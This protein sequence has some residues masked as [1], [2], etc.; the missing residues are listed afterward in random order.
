[1][2]VFLLL[3]VFIPIILGALL[4]LNPVQNKVVDWA[5][6]FAS[7]QLETEISIGAIYIEPFTTLRID[8]V[9][10]RD[11]EAD[12]L[13]FGES[14]FLELAHIDFKPLNVDLA[15]LR[16]RKS[17]FNLQT[18]EG[19]SLSNLQ[20]LLNKL[21]KSEKD[22]SS[23]A[24]SLYSASLVLDSLRFVM[25]NNN[26]AYVNNGA[27]DFNHLEVKNLCGRFQ[28]IQIVDDSISAFVHGMSC[29][30]KSGLIIRHFTSAAQVSNGK[31][32]ANE[33]QLV[34]NKGV[35]KGML[36]MTG[37]NWSAYSDFL[38]SVQL[39]ASLVDSKIFFDDLGYF[40]PSIKGLLAPMQF[41][42]SID[43]TISH[44]SA[45]VDTLQFANSGSLRGSV[46]IN[47]LPNM[48]STFIDANLYELYATLDDI[49]QLN[50]PNGE[51]AYTNITL[52][53]SLQKLAFIDF[54]GRFTGFISDFNTYGTITTDMGVLETD[55]NIKTGDVL[56][57]KGQ[58]ATANF[59]LGTLLDAGESVG[60]IGFQLDVDGS[61][62]DLKSLD[63][64]AKGL[65]HHFEVL[66]YD[67]QKIQLNGK[68]ANQVFKGKVKLGD[69]NVALDFNGEID[70]ADKLPHIK[71][72]MVIDSLLLGKLNLV[73]TDTHGVI[74]GIAEL[75]LNGNSPRTLN[76][77]L[78][79]REV[80]YEN[81]IHGIKLDTL[82]IVDELLKE[83]HHISVTSDIL[84]AEV[85]GGTSI[86]DL[87]YAIT[88]VAHHYMPTLVPLVTLDD[89][90]TTQQFKFSLSIDND[91][92]LI[93]L[94]SEELKVKS[95]LRLSGEVNTVGNSFLLHVDTLNWSYGRMSMIRNSVE[96]YPAN[97]D[98]IVKL[99]ADEFSMSETYQLQQLR[100]GATIIKDSVM[101]IVDWNNYTSQAD[102]GHVAFTFYRDTLHPYN[103]V[104]NELEVKVADVT[105]TSNKTAVLRADT[106]YVQVKDLYLESERGLVTCSGTINEQKESHLYFKMKNFDLSYL[107]NFGLMEQSLAG[108][109]ESQLDLSFRSGAFI[110][111][112][113]VLADSLKIDD[114]EIG[115][116]AGI[117]NYQNELKRLDVDLDLTYQK[118]SEFDLK[119]AYYPFNDNDQL[120]LTASFH[121]FRVQSLEP[122]V[123]DMMNNMDG[124]VAG[125]I[126]ISGRASSPQ[127]SGALQ[128]SDVTTKVVYLNTQYHIPSGRV[129][130]QPQ[131]IAMQDVS[132]Y[133]E[134]ES[135]AVLNLDFAHQN[136]DNY[137]YSVLL[138]ADNFL[139][140]NTTISEN[141]DYYGVANIS[142]DV[143]ISGRAELT[144]IKVNASTD[145]NTRLAI[146]LSGGGEVSDLDYIRF[147]DKDGFEV[148]HEDKALREELKGLEMDFKLSVDN[149]A[150]VQIIFDEKV[151]D[152]IKVRGNGDMLLKIDNR[153]QFNM[154][155]DYVINSGDYLF[156]LQNVV[157]KRFIVESGSRLVWNGDPTKA[158]VDIT[159][160]YELK[161]SPSLMVK[162]M[163]GDDNSFYEQRLPVHVYL[164]MDG[165]MTEPEISFDVSLPTL[166]ETDIANQ[167]LNR[168]IATEEQINTQ[169][170]SLLLAGQFSPGNGNVALG[171][172]GQSTGFEMISN[173]LSNWASKYSDK[174]D[175]GIN[176]R[177][178]YVDET[179]VENAS[180]TELSLST[181][182]LNDRLKIE[183]NG[184]VQGASSAGEEAQNNNLA[185]EF[186]VEYNIN[187]DGSLK[188][189]AFN[190]AN[191]YN[192]A[193][194]NQSPYTQ[195][196]GLFYRKEFNT[197]GQFFRDLFGGGKKQSKQRS[198]EP[199]EEKPEDDES[200]GQ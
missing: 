4:L 28:D 113:D 19:D 40:A 39:E 150:Q 89:A 162:N 82:V 29:Q 129:N 77:S 16:L 43:G 141:E 200:A 37:E 50:I 155:G 68:V 87:P 69:K 23:T 173:Q 177:D 174:F 111:D 160:I 197:W 80:S 154:Y 22:T 41:A 78:E 53:A 45:N 106:N 138:E 167:L 7:K 128:L 146:P 9:L 137:S 42:G 109:F 27:V 2:S 70:F 90:D 74:R 166:S 71:S 192:P 64:V 143:S 110:I 31:L 65:I 157:N 136:F 3:L 79:L 118:E 175:V 66:E 184:T 55:I 76:G 176:Y 96:V 182:V 103:A 44:L 49:H 108:N 97:T 195:G 181:A 95:P 120:D 91:R 83:G 188:A 20:H 123:A 165:V 67:Y 75:N 180:E 100:V 196:I 85:Y 24:F 144:S 105:W 179:G 86:P 163:A 93:G 21:P 72:S 140:L 47:G 131:S 183:V 62:A 178:S 104:L 159:A 172:T 115:R 73:P 88:K 92:D 126:D 94:F 139:C 127:L 194:L 5:S 186:N 124:T 36:R 187:Q 134:K 17:Y 158:R 164:N 13:L 117:A 185:G 132:V 193:N 170:F 34:T 149:D 33:L 101:A 46:N 98:L 189:R 199:S 25:D 63:V 56:Q 114:I 169:A 122:L 54:N 121:G 10:V 142:G 125:E 112:G 11:L 130:V 133:D 191:N 81:N 48:D 57:Y 102:S 116:I 190:E 12:T 32:L 52:P 6:A 119:G 18:A 99:N 38:N 35:I 1:M 61:G 30:E 51:G 168:N 14:V 135:S 60:D 171:G 84:N 161:A 15:Q 58:M 148:K 8:S 151:G 59:R 107:S 147:V 145:K 153:G 26:H 156:T 152:I 198:D